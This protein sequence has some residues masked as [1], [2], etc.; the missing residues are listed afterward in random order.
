MKWVRSPRAQPLD[1]WHLD[2]LLVTIGDAK[3]WYWRTVD[4]KGNILDV[5]MQSRLNAKAPKRFISRLVTRWGKPL[6][7]VTD[8]LHSDG[9]A[10]RKLALAADHR[11]HN[12]LNNRTE[13]SHRPTRKQEQIP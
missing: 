9:E 4:S 5:F 12:E 11:A 6:E 7:I 10:L 3:Y 2:E 13:K 1:H 8:K